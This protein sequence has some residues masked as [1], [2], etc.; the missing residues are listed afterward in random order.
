MA[1]N[2]TLSDLRKAGTV[3]SFEIVAAVDAYIINPAAGPYRF[4]SGHSLDIATVIGSSA[5]FAGMAARTGPKEKT[6]RTA[7]T[8]VAMR[9]EVM[10][11]YPGL[12]Q[13]RRPA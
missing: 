6:F 10:L 3:T 7:V 13:P 12:G 4:A 9:A 1:K 5:E 8:T 11:P 2:P